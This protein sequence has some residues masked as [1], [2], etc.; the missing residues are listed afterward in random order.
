MEVQEKTLR[1]YTTEERLEMLTLCCMRYEK[2]ID[3]LVLQNTIMQAK[4]KNISE[5]LNQYKNKDLNLDNPIVATIKSVYQLEDYEYKEK[6]LT[7][8]MIEFDEFIDKLYLHRSKGNLDGLQQGS[9]ATFKIE[10]DR[11]KDFKSIKNI[12]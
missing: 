5:K 4:V 6:I 12:M 10:G 2:A 3:D 1:V 7:V 11:I 8:Y 9:K